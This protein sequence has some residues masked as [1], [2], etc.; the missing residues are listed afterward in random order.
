MTF[1]AV[2]FGIV[3][4]MVYASAFHFWKGGSLARILVYVI[5]SAVGYWTGHLVGARL[6]WSFWTIGPINNGM[7]TLGSLIFL[8]AGEWL[9]R[10]EI[11]EKR[12]MPGNNKKN[13]PR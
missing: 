3:L 12:L 13:P 11:N 6:G 4:S 9:S 8:F 1:P 10:V 2:L 7:A 5:I